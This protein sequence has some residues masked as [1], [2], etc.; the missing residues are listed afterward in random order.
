[1]VRSSFTTSDTTTSATL[2]GFNIGELT[3]G[4]DLLLSVFAMRTNIKRN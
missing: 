3:F 2:S 4:V 1:M